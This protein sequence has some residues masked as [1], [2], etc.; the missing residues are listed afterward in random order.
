M[1]VDS[2]NIIV[3]A[4][5]ADLEQICQWVDQLG[6]RWELPHNTLFAIQLCCEEGFS[7]VARHGS[8]HKDQDHSE[9]NQVLLKLN[10][11][12]DEV[13]LEIEDQ[14]IPF[15]PLTM[16]PPQTPKSIDEVK[17]GGLGVHLMKKFSSKINYERRGH[18][19]H[20]SIHFSLFSPTNSLASTH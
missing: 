10:L 18:L 17:V 13:N 12:E 16:P 20:L 1:N 14:G 15:N 19:N 4:D 6:N 8:I 5:L 2:S 9:S 3:S 11:K 7:N